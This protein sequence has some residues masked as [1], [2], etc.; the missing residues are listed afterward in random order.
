MDNVLCKVVKYIH[1]PQELAYKQK[2]SKM[3]MKGQDLYKS[4]QA[5]AQVLFCGYV[6]IYMFSDFMIDA[7]GE[8]IL[9]ITVF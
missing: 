8:N 3:E 7:C 6:S 1:C 4:N 2:Q 5:A 9:T